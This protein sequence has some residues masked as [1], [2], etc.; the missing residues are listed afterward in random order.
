MNFEELVAVF[1]NLKRFKLFINYYHYKNIINELSLGIRGVVWKFCQINREKNFTITQTALL[2]FR[3]F[4]FAFYI[5]LYSL[6]PI[7]EALIPLRRW[8]G[9]RIYL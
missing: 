4:T 6:E 7:S 2:F 3:I 8:Y 1:Q 5:L 9:L